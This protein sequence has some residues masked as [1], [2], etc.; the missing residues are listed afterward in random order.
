VQRDAPDANRGRSFA[1][2]ETRFQLIWVI[3][4]L[5]PILI[6]IPAALGFGLIAISASVAVAFYLVGLRNVRAGRV[7]IPRKG[8]LRRPIEID[9]RHPSVQ[10]DLDSTRAVDLGFAG[11][12]TPPAWGPPLDP[13]DPTAADIDVA[14]H[15]A[16]R[17][18]MRRPMTTAPAPA[19]ETSPIVPT[20]PPVL[21]PSDPTTVEWPFP[22]LSADTPSATNDHRSGILFD[23]DAWDDPE[24][25][26]GPPPIL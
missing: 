24:V 3:G 8:V 16:A 4:A 12:E 23:S 7:P 6:P 26:D 11:P 13:T 14:P 25:P 20:A 18:W 10:D 22:E 2:F 19:S 1:K 15:D 9:G 21:P 5:V 17:R